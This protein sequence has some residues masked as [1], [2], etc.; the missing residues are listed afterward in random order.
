MEKTKS[1]APETWPGYWD[2]DSK[3]VPPDFDLD[4]G[5]YGES[6]NQEAN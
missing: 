5:D 4:G 1:S 2:W 3:P 6:D